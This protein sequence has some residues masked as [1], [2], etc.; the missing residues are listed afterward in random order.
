M[1]TSS[2][3]Q[4]LEEKLKLQGKITILGKIILF[5]KNGTSL[6]SELREKIQPRLVAVGSIKAAVAQYFL[7]VDNKFILLH[8]QS[9]VKVFDILFKNYFVFNTQYDSNLISFYRFLQKYFYIYKMNSDPVTPRI[10]E[11]YTLLRNQ[12]NISI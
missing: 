2:S 12:M 5:K 6:E 8:V 10:R 1:S 4:R 9:F 3:P 11:V 7:N